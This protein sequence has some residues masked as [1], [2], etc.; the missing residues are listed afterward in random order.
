[1]ERDHGYAHLSIPFQIKQSKENQI[2]PCITYH[3][4]S[5]GIGDIYDETY[6]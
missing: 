3:G 4:V 2:R 6:F 5:F 1:M